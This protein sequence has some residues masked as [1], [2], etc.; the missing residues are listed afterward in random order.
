MKKCRNR[1]RKETL[2]VQDILAEENVAFLDTE[3]LT[4]QYKGGPPSKLVSIGFVICRQGFQEIRRFHSYIYMEDELHDKFKELTGISEAE[5]QQAP[6]YEDV[7]DSVTQLLEKWEVA[8]IFVWGPDE[9]II[10]KDMEFYRS[11][12]SKRLRKAINREIRKVKDIEGIYSGKL[13]LKN[14]GISNLKILCNL[15]TEVKHNALSDAVD[16]KNVIRTIDEEGCPAHL[17]QAMRMYLHDKELYYRNRR[18][19]DQWIDIPPRIGEAGK[20]FL[21]ALECLDTMEAMALHDDIQVICTGKNQSF[22]SAEEYIRAKQ[23][24]IL[25]H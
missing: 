20:N 6:E 1:P 12:I 18:F 13:G 9:A 24:Q 21:E 22:P 23:E 16:L 17:V 2:T 10:K 3:F 7:M 19:R 25:E 8:H 14:L 5:L 11:G 15:G 4:S